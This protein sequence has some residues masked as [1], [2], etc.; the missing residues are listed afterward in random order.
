MGHNGTQYCWGTIPLNVGKLDRD[1]NR[2]SHWRPWI[3]LPIFGFWA[4]RE[5]GFPPRVAVMGGDG[6]D[7]PD[8][9]GTSRHMVRGESLSGPGSGT[10]ER[11]MKPNALK[12]D[13]ECMCS[14][15]KHDSSVPPSHC[16][17]RG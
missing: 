1:G 10:S 15:R 11:G 4:Y 7:G 6:P 13:P 2:G 16:G 9:V 3:R 12:V 8:L 17:A 5:P 14:I